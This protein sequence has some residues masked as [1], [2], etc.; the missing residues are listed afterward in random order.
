MPASSAFYKGGIIWL[1]VGVCTLIVDFSG[2]GAEYANWIRT[3]EIMEG[4]IDG[5]GPKDTEAASRRGDV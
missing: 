4:G 1:T 2:T 3:R 5:H